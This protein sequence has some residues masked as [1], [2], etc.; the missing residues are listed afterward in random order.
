MFVK[1]CP[2]I[3]LK[4]HVFIKALGL[5][6]LLIHSHPLYGIGFNPILEQALSEPLSSFF[7]GNEQH[8]QG[9]VLDPHKS[10]GAA[11]I[12]FCDHQMR[13]SSER[14]RYIFFYLFDF[15]V[16]Q[17]QV[18]CSYRTFPRSEEHTSELQS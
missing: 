13:N 9:A 16:R 8:F 7:R 17:K 11:P 15:T 4:A 1:V 10:P 2:F 12:I 14:L 18:C 5:W 6:V 3:N